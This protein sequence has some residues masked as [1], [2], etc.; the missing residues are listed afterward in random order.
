[1]K[2]QALTAIL[3]AVLTAASGSAFADGDA[4]KG[5]KV[6]TSKCKAC[7]TIDEGGKNKLGPNLFAVFGRAPGEV[8]GYKYSKSYKAAAEKGLVWNEEELEEYLENPRDFIRKA[9]GDP[10][11]RSKMTLKLSKEDDRDDVIAYLKTMK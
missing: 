1:M 2:R 6:F 8:A 7:H 5:E 10:K 4:A 3:L 9:S 11:G